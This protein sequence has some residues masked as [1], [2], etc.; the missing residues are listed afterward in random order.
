MLIPSFTHR[1]CFDKVLTS[2]GTII[3]RKLLNVLQ[4]NMLFVVHVKDKAVP[5]HS[6]KPYWGSRG[7]APLIL[8]LGTRWI[9][10]VNLKPRPL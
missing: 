6:V 4:H 7:I 1:T 2:S 10:V 9:Y 3:K 5:D 8:N